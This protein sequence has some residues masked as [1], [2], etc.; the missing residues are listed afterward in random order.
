METHKGY[1]GLMRASGSSGKT[2]L[3]YA[4]PSYEIAYH[5]VTRMLGT[6]DQKVEKIYYT[7]TK[8]RKLGELNP[9]HL[10]SKILLNGTLLQVIKIILNG[11][12]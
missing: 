8:Y 9:S 1:L 11:N 12:H 5:V 4:S 10:V 6:D 2:I 7:F 3:Y